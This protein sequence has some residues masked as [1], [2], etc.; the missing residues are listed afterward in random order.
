VPIV[1]EVADD[2]FALGAFQVKV[3]GRVRLFEGLELSL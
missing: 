2:E 1:A 3:R